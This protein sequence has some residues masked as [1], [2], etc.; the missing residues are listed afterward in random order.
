MALA[1]EILQSVPHH[2]ATGAENEAI[3]AVAEEFNLSFL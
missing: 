1:Q 2:Q 3:L